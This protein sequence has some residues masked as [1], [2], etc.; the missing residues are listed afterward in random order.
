MPDEK[1]EHQQAKLAEPI[2]GASCCTIHSSPPTTTEGGIVTLEVALP[3]R[4]GNISCAWRVE[5]E[6]GKPVGTLTQVGAL[7]AQL[8]TTGLRP[9][10]YRAIA[11]LKP[12]QGEAVP[13]VTESVDVIVTPRPL[14]AGD[15]LSVSVNREGNGEDSLSVT[16]NRAATTPTE[17]LA[18]WTV[19]RQTT[20]AISFNNYKQFMDRIMCGQADRIASPI[21]DSDDPI[22][23]DPKNPPR[24]Y[25]LSVPFPG[26]DAYNLLK[27]A[28]EVFL[29]ANCGVAINFKN[30]ASK[31]LMQE[32]R[33][34]GVPVAPKNIP[35]VIPGLINDLWNEYRVEV[36]GKVPGDGTGPA[37]TLPYLALIRSKLGDLPLKTDTEA[38]NC[39]G[40]L[41]RK[42]TNPCLLELIWSYWHEEGM[43]VQTMKTISLRFQN[44]RVGTNGD[45]LAR[46][47]IDPLRPLGNLLWGYI[48]DEQHRLTIVRRAYEYDHHYGISLHGKAVPALRPADSRSKFLEAFHN[49]LDLCADFFKEDDDTTVIADGFPVMNALKEVHLL[50]AEGAHNQFGDLP[51]TA[52]QEMLIEQWLLARPEMREFLGGRIMVPYAEIWMDRVDHVKRLRDWTDVTVTH[53]HDLAAFG[54][55]I[56]L[57]IRYGSWSEVYDPAHAANWARYWRPEIQSYIHGYRAVTGVDLTQDA[58]EARQ[59]NERYTQP[60]VHLRRRLDRQ[61][62]SVRR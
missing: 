3:L 51:S 8:D 33:R 7:K 59:A 5:D 56:L 49:L 13:S 26:V 27:T 28:T 11:T 40:I 54:E 20:Q 2:S 36:E 22:K 29:M 60:S 15:H 38:A 58:S 50:L 62:A 61:L 37:L 4:G 24:P 6:F 14:A 41:Q 1:Q 9:A 18:L 43:L 45:P 17:D 44:K 55:Q 47:D 46:L 25:R 32:A 21:S 30:L 12:M 39:Y 48:Q 23:F 19:I 31:D 53:F 35:K 10:R 16:L 42:L 34:Y 52:R 57:S